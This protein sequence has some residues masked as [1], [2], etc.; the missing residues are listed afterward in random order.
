MMAKKKKLKN[1]YIKIIS[2]DVFSQTQKTLKTEES[3]K[4][5][6][7]TIIIIIEKNALNS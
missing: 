3:I 1:K 5:N 2:L 6:K 7:Q 4:R